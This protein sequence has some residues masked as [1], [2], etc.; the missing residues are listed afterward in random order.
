MVAGWI[1]NSK[2]VRRTEVRWWSLVGGGEKKK[3]KRKEKKRKEWP[4]RFKDNSVEK[5]LDCDLI[6]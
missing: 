2:R 5:N 1:I 3:K 4:R 6:L